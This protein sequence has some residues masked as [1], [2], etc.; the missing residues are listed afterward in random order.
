MSLSLNRA[1]SCLINLMSVCQWTESRP[2]NITSLSFCAAT[3]RAPGDDDSTNDIIRADVDQCVGLLHPLNVEMSL[4]TY[5]LLG[6]KGCTAHPVK[7][8]SV[9]LRT[10]LAFRSVGLNSQIIKHR[11]SFLRSRLYC[12]VNGFVSCSIDWMHQ[13]QGNRPF[14]C[15]D[16]LDCIR[17]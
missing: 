17:T 10:M 5:E 15:S 4:H 12:L 6:V 14:Q 1:V 13:R 2:Q 9:Q 3:G 16:S 7:E 8:K 11:L